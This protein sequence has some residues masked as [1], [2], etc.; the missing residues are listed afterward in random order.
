MLSPAHR[1]L[2]RGCCC[3]LTDFGVGGSVKR[4]G[5]GLEHPNIGG[6]PCLGSVQLPSILAH[7]LA[8]SAIPWPPN[9]QVGAQPKYL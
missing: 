2:P 9:P 3:F 8:P 5:C 6:P 1:C 7:H 4:L